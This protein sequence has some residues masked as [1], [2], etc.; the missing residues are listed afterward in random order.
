MLHL[1]RS[2]LD[3]L[4]ALPRRGICPATPGHTIWNTPACPPRGVPAHFLAEI[5]RKLFD[6]SPC[7]RVPGFWPVP[8]DLDSIDTITL[9]SE[10]PLQIRYLLYVFLW[11]S[12]LPYDSTIQRLTRFLLPQDRK[13]A[14]T[15]CTLG[16]VLDP[17]LGLWWDLA[18][19]I[20]EMTHSSP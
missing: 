12:F 20:S 3:S 2:I 14:F 15:V 7:L 13:V 4:V 19:D 11:L 18:S 10:L 16:N 17:G 1:P 9:G 5:L 8:R 6:H